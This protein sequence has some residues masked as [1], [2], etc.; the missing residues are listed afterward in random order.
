MNKLNITNFQEMAALFGASNYND[1]GMKYALSF[2]PE[3]Y[4]KEWE[5]KSCKIYRIVYLIYK[6]VDVEQMVKVEVQYFDK[7][8]SKLH[9][10]NFNF[11]VTSFKDEFKLLVE[12]KIK[13]I[14]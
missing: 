11:K 8:L 3:R 7:N 12:S 4:D 6:N 9:Q 1:F 2:N 13:C 10:H 5:C 14:V